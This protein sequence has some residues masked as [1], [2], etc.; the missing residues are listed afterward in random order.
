MSVF[1]NGVLKSSR[2]VNNYNAAQRSIY[3]GRGEGDFRSLFGIKMSRIAV[4]DGALTNQDIMKIATI[5]PV[6]R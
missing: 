2:Y 3:V 5:S 1:L 4:Y 6:Q